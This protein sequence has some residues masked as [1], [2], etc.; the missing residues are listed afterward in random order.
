MHRRAGWGLLFVLVFAGC[1]T[2]PA[3]LERVYVPEGGASVRVDVTR[4]GGRALAG[5]F[6][7]R[8]GAGEVVR[9]VLGR[10]REV[11][12][13]RGDGG[14]FVW[15]VG[16]FPGTLW[17]L[18][19]GVEG[20]ERGGELDYPGVGEVEWFE[21]KDGEGVVLVGRAAVGYAEQGWEGVRWREVREVFAW[22][23]R[24]AEV[25]WEAGAVPVVGTLAGMERVR[26]WGV[27]EEGVWEHGMR[28]EYGEGVSLRGV[29]TLLRLVLPGM[30]A[31]VFE[32]DFLDTWNAL[33]FTEEGEALGVRLP[34]V[35]QGELERALE[36]WFGLGE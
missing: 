1:A 16:G 30:F 5:W 4:P 20:W 12:L 15:C 28:W 18:G 9:E 14:W 6:V 13:V 8:M 21:G 24:D 36:A 22:P 35:S 7:E 17:R 11:F 25:V 26:W 3:V 2:G 32:R 34:V 27:E 19:L 31:A 33:E 10:S 23:T 29:R